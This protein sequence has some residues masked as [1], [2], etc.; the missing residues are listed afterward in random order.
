MADF[1][2]KGKRIHVRLSKGDF[3]RKSRHHTFKL[4][5][6][7]TA[8][9]D[10]ITGLPEWVQNAYTNLAK[11]ANLNPFQRLEVSVDNAVL[12]FFPTQ[13]SRTRLWAPILG[14][15]LTNFEMERKGTEE[16]L[17]IRL[18]F[19]ATFPWNKSA[20]D[21]V[22]SEGDDD[23]WLSAESPQ[24]DLNLTAAQE[25]A[26]ETSDDE[27]EEEEDETE[28]EDDD[29]DED[30]EEEDEEDSKPEPARTTPLVG[31]V[32]RRTPNPRQMPN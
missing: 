11:F 4:V 8:D 30:E 7:L 6:D 13:K 22:G 14:A 29:S 10:T 24:Q 12:E 19:N 2:P 15:Q 32:P 31:L 17:S 28:E 5:F 20:H 16:S 18:K 9:G 25:T 26:A 1:I 23:F 21:F 3:N 27:D